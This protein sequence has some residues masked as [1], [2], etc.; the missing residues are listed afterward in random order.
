M[1]SMPKINWHKLA[2]FVSRSTKRMQWHIGNIWN[3]EKIFFSQKIKKFKALDR[4]YYH[5]FSFL[6]LQE[7]RFLVPVVPRFRL[8]P[9]MLVVETV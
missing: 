2:K 5:Y 4:F 9:L 1:G 6:L 8:I 7:M 3:V